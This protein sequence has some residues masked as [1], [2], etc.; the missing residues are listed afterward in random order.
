MAPVVPVVGD[1]VRPFVGV[2]TR[3]D[4]DDRLGVAEIEDFVR[5]AGL[6]VDEVAGAVLDRLRAGG[7]RIRGVPGR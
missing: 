1:D 5:D 6:D 4:G 3:H 2:G 7:R